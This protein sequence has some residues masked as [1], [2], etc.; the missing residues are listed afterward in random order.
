MTTP[1]HPIRS[2]LLRLVCAVSTHQPIRV[3]TG[4][5]L[6]RMSAFGDVQGT[7]TN[8]HIECRRCTKQLEREKEPKP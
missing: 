6:D 1:P 3:I 2:M 8:D 5:R 7:I 4:V